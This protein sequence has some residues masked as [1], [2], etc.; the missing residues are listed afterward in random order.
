MKKDNEMQRVAKDTYT[1]MIDK[2][3]LNLQKPVSENQ[4]IK[5]IIKQYLHLTDKD[6]ISVRK[7][8]AKETESVPTY[9]VSVKYEKPVNF[10][11][12]KVEIEADI[13]KVGK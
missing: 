1:M 4:T 9:N 7:K 11:T 10:I 13:E 3:I 2:L 6:K 12:L 5:A 8:R